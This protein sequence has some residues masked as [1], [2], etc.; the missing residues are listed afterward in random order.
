MNRTFQRNMFRKILVPILHGSDFHD[1]L[2]VARSIAS[3]ESILLAGMVA[4]A[5][6]KNLSAG[7]LPAQ[8]LRKSFRQIKSKQEIRSLELIRVTQQP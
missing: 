5:N 2:L 1:S 8:E 4:V 3:A 7:A 6:D